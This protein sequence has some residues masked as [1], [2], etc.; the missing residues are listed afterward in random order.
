MFSYILVSVFIFLFPVYVSAFV[1]CFF[2]FFGSLTLLSGFFVRFIFPD[3]LSVPVPYV[4]LLPECFNL[5]IKKPGLHLAPG[6]LAHFMIPVSTSY[7]FRICGPTAHPGH[8]IHPGVKHS[9]TH[10]SHP[11]S[12]YCICHHPH[13]LPVI[14]IITPA[15]SAGVS[16]VLGLY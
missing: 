9:T 16:F 5:P 12:N 6:R 8:L 15:L 2:L 1:F 11:L 4:F 13:L 14:L 7:L 3:I 10:T